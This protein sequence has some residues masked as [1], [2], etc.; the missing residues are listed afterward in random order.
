[1]PLRADLRQML[2]LYSPSPGEERH[3]ERMERLLDAPGDVFSRDHFE[4]GHFT[5]S[6]FVIS[7]DRSS[8]ALVHHQR[9]DR[10]LQPGG[11]V[12]PDDPTLASA[13]FREVEEEIGVMAQLLAPL[14]FDIDIHA[15]PARGDEPA[16]EHFDI[17][18][19]FEAERVAL[20]AGDGVAA[21][22]W[23]P[24]AAV[25]EFTLDDSVIRAATKIGYL[26]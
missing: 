11:H 21:A 2:D 8:L 20:A 14:I 25:G 13:A 16:H 9:L 7:M 12:E 4:P 24:L 10:W 6:A 1:M 23:V 22:R 3:F 19:V 17:R 18:F 26:R 15:I 5:A